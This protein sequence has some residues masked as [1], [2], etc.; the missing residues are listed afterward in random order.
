V[1]AGRPL[2]IADFPNHI[3]ITQLV[4]TLEQLH[5]MGG[6]FADSKWLHAL[7]LS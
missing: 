3:H 2:P 1:T 4:V 6:Q 5:D 7:I